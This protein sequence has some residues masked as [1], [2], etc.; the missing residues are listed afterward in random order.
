MRELPSI[1]LLPLEDICIH[2]LHYIRAAI[3]NRQVHLDPVY[4]GHR[5][6]S[7]IVV[8]TLLVRSWEGEDECIGVPHGGPECGNQSKFLDWRVHVMAEDP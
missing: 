1:C 3:I 4:S 6:A 8:N 2:S 7:C 5:L